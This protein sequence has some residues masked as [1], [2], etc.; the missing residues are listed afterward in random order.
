MWN[1]K[2]KVKPIK[3]KKNSKMVFTRGQ[4]WGITQMVFKGRNLKLAVNKHNKMNIIYNT[5]Q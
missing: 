2:K 4:R 3:R 1:L 5:V